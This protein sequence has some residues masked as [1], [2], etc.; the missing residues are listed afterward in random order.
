MSCND[1]DINQPEVV[2]TGRKELTRVLESCEEQ[3]IK[4]KNYMKELDV[5]REQKQEKQR[6]YFE[7]EIEIT[8]KNLAEANETIHTKYEALSK[9]FDSQCEKV[10]PKDSKGVKDPN[11]PKFCQE[12][13][14]LLTRT[15]EWMTNQGKN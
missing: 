3:T 10:N 1:K 4:L 5:A 15:K 11:Y 7:K 9:N 12:T 2:E 6:E 13:R 14:D 8:K